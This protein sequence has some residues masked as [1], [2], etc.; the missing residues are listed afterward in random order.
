MGMFGEI[1]NEGTARD[2]AKALRASLIWDEEVIRFCKKH[3]YPLYLDARAEAWGS[4]KDDDADI[5]KIYSTPKD[6]K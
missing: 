1:H 5:E 6:E 2:L 3:I 4:Y